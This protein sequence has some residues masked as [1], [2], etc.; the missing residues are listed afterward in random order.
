[1]G[2]E[3]ARTDVVRAGDEVVLGD[4]LHP[5]ERLVRQIRKAGV[6]DGNDHAVTGDTAVVQLGHSN[7]RELFD[8]RAVVDRRLASGG[9]SAAPR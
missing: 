1:M 3:I 9:R 2:G 7:L 4:D 5:R 6:E 8:R